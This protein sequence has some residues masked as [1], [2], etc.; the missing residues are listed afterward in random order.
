MANTC[1]VSRDGFLH[2]RLYIG[3]LQHVASFFD[4][5]VV[6]N[7]VA[8][9]VVERVLFELGLRA[10]PLRKELRG[11]GNRDQHANRHVQEGL[12]GA[13]ELS[14]NEVEELSRGQT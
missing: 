5:A 3:V 9:H 10:H 12:L 14:R 11:R 1:D 6:P 8:G 2:P 13:E 7:A 4:L